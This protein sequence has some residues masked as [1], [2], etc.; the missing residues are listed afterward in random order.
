MKKKKTNQNVS[1]SDVIGD[2]RVKKG[3]THQIIN[4]LKI[5]EPVKL[6]SLVKKKTKN[7][8]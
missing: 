4:I 1:A 5:K 7:I 6:S 8:C 2:L 3:N